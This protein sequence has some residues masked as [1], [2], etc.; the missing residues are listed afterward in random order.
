MVH[1]QVRYGNGL[2][3]LES[4]KT[5]AFTNFGLKFFESSGG[6]VRGSDVIRFLV[7]GDQ[8]HAGGAHGSHTDD[9][10]DEMIENSLNREICDHRSRE[11]CE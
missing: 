3:G 8:S 7:C 11:L 10:L 1:R 6:L 4:G 9:P 5:G 2:A